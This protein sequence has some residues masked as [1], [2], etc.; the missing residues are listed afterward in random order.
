MIT[1]TGDQEVPVECKNIPRGPVMELK[2]LK[3]EGERMETIL[4]AI[5]ALLNPVGK[6]AK[7]QIHW[8][9]LGQVR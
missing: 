2:V 5:P 7:G 4:T 9:A 3:A 8:W 6:V 1:S